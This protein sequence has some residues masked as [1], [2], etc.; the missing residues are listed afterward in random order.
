MKKHLE[1]IWV[2]LLASI[3]CAA[4]VLGMV[5]SILPSVIIW[6]NGG[7]D[8]M[9]KDV[10]EKIYQNYAIYVYDEL[11]NGR[12][13]EMEEF[14]SKH[15]LAAA[16]VKNEQTVE[17]DVSEDSSENLSGAKTEEQPEDQNSESQ[18]DTIGTSSDDMDLAG[19]YKLE[20]SEGYYYNYNVDSLLA[21]LKCGFYEEEHMIPTRVTEI[22]Y[23]EN[24][25]I[26]YYETERGYYEVTYIYVGEGEYN[27]DY[28]LRS[29]GS[30]KYYYNSYY[31]KI[32]DP[33]AFPTWEWVQI[34]DIDMYFGSG[35]T[36]DNIRIADNTQEIEDA[37][38]TESYYVTSMTL[39][40]EDT[41]VLPTTTVY[42]WNLAEETY[43]ATEA[44]NLFIEWNTLLNNLTDVENEMPGLVIGYLLL[45][46]FGI[47]LLGFA[48]PSHKEQIGFFHKIPVF[49]YTF[50][51]GCLLVFAIVIVVYLMDD[52]YAGNHYMPIDF[53]IS[54]S[55]ML[56]AAGFFVGFL[57]LGNII[58]RFKTGTFFRYSEFYYITKP[59]H[60]L[61]A[62]AKEHVPLFWKGVGILVVITL[63]EF[64]ILC[65]NCHSANNLVVWFFLEKLLVSGV[66]IYVLLQMKELQDGSSRIAQGDLSSPINTD[67]LLWEFKKHGENLN[68]VSESISLAVQD[69]LK[70]E[71]FK[72]EL[73]TN[74]SHDIKTPLTSMINYVDLIK[75]ENPSDPKLCEY[76]EVLDRQSARLKKLIE[77]LMEASK[78]STG[79]LAVELQEC[80][81]D[82]LLTQIVGEFE[83]KLN[84][85]AL[86]LIVEKPEETL[87]VNADG[88]HMWRVLDNL[89]GNICKYA[90]PNTRVYLT[91]QKLDGM[92]VITFK[93]ISQSAL[94][95]P[96][97]EL[98]ERFVR[99][100]SSR[101]TEG[102]GL[103]LS[104]AQSL[105]ELMGGTMQLNIDGDLFKVTLRFPVI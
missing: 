40:Y 77:D 87:K 30:K 23:D 49:I 93:N 29:D 36:N 53:S 84:A 28:T 44:T 14:L 79:N 46:L 19:A 74:V 65:V 22:V 64:T 70:S 39:Y 55:L 8:R 32:L 82:V 71:R 81:I 73:I 25:G 54:V 102:S 43:T 72:T 100:D 105:T 50:C 27:Y 41:E 12:E 76:V 2:R 4:A 31:D 91:L 26:F 21:A 34:E 96:S 9:N 80:D 88:R 24:T 95:I 51:V 48:A 98:L 75:K 67:R 20:L 78:A 83:A 11:K 18:I 62:L 61:S 85:S 66:V 3:I 103:G 45:L 90:M 97:E 69:Q 56:A 94:N 47:L 13:E 33:Q 60:R 57:Y 99:G 101:N 17:N 1:T 59:V 92:A 37:L 15:Q 6:E 16:V 52:I 89:M 42:I 104:I 58:G 35:K 7:K 86:E 5:Y 68:S 38:C 10:Q 63:I